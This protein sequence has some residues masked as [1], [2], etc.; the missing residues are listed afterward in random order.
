MKKFLK[1]AEG[2][3]LVELIVV[4][5]ILGILAAVAVPA[6]NG[7]IDKAN[8][9]GDNQILS[10]VKTAADAALALEVDD[11]TSLVVSADGTTV[12]AYYP[13]GSDSG[14]DPDPVQL[15][16]AVADAT[17]AQEDFATYFEGNTITFKS[18]DYKANGATWTSEGWEPTASADED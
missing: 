5:A 2:F 10:A 9:A 13:D 8:E 17:D 6:Y 16:P 11:Y 15:F 7:Y 18:E 12:T 1:K 4:I 3:T 14:D